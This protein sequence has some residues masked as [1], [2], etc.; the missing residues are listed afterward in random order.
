[1]VAILVAKRDNECCD[2][3]IGRMPVIKFTVSTLS[4][5]GFKLVTKNATRKIAVNDVSFSTSATQAFLG[6]VLS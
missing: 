4:L 1:M 3:N 5:V 6:I 2:R